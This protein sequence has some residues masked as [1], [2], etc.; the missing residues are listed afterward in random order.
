VAHGD[1]TPQVVAGVD[2]TAAGRRV[3]DRARLIAEGLDARL[4]LIHVVEPMAEAFIEPALA[5]LVWDSERQSARELAA[6]CES[7]TSIPVEVEVVKGSPSWELAS[8]SKDAEVVVVGSSSIDAFT[9]G[10]T[11]RRLARKANTHILVVRRQPRVAYR[12]VLVAVD[13][14]EA[15]GQGVETALAL[16]PKAEV[17]LV[18]C[19]PARFDSLLKRAGL[20][21]EELDGSRTRRLDAARD[22]MAEF[23]ARWG[24][25]VKTMVVDGPTPGAVDEAVRQ[26]SADLVVVSSRG[27]TATR[28]VLLG[29]VA[30]EM[31]GAIPCDVL[32]ARVKSAFRRP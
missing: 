7:R 23:A 16:F 20:F 8:R 5:Q 12:R 6:W 19:L 25:R 13:F 27:A 29:S 1:T 10:P 31:L 28:M 2:L 24:N 18:H 15:S 26:R 22:R 11:A 32:V 30:E 17:T 14:S 9:V 3:A 4:R 21:Q